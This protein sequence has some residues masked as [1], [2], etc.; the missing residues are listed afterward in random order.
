MSKI[1]AQT[2]E[3]ETWELL[4][5]GV[6]MRVDNTSRQFLNSLFQVEKKNGG[7]VW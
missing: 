6:M 4:K 2:I 5:K 7:T 3:N 1:Q